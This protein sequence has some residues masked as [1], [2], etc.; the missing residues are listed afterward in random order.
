M[1]SCDGPGCAHWSRTP[2]S[3]RCFATTSKP[4]H[5]RTQPGNG[6]Q[7]RS[8]ASLPRP[9]ALGEGAGGLG[10]SSMRGDRA[11]FDTNVFVYLFDEDA[12]AKQAKAR[13]LFER[14]G[15]AGQIALSPQVLQEL[16]VTVTR[17]LA[18]P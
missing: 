15:R 16:Y 7:T 14:L 1:K 13:K 11:F 12:P 5:P 8:F 9:K 4:S 17:K 2:R 10:T 3:T 18:R 6:P